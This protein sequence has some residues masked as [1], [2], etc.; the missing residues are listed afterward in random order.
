MGLLG[1]TI[2]EQGGSL[3]NVRYGNVRNHLTKI[4]MLALRD[5]LL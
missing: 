5:R 3:G 1:T 2:P 4:L